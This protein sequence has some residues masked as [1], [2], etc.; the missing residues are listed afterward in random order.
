VEYSEDDDEE[1]PLY[2]DPSMVAN[3]GISTHLLYVHALSNRETKNYSTALLSYAK[4]MKSE[5]QLDE[6]EKMINRENTKNLDLKIV[7]APGGAGWLVDIYS[8]FKR[9]GLL[10]KNNEWHMLNLKEH[11]QLKEGFSHDRIDQVVRDLQRIRFF[12]RFDRETLYQMIGKCDLRVI[13][14]STLLF[15]E[16]D[17]TA[18]LVKGHIHMFTHKDDVSTPRLQAIYTPGHILGNS[19]IDGG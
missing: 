12:N 15:L 1:D 9:M 6:Y 3:N 19:S 2:I 8:H 11:Y 7:E 17:E 4:V 16:E 14:R 10:K 18:V 13:T 5:Q